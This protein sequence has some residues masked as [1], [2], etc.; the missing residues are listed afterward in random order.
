MKRGNTPLDAKTPVLPEV[1]IFFKLGGV[2]T[3]PVLSVFAQT[4]LLSQLKG[5]AAPLLP[6]AGCYPCCPA[7]RNVFSIR[8]LARVPLSAPLLRSQGHEEDL[9]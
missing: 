5:F 2:E 6:K 7:I 9:L 8:F 4:K 3:P 1:S